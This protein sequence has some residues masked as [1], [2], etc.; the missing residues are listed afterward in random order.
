MLC[1]SVVEQMAAQGGF[2]LRP[3]CARL[4]TNQNM[5]TC[6]MPVARLWNTFSCTY[7][8]YVCVCVL[9]SVWTVLSVCPAEVAG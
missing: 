5:C 1:T 3:H 2:I 8:N 7:Y 9:V 4:C 6:L